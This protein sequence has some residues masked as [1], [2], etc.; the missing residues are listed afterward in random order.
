MKIL[1]SEEEWKVY[2]EKLHRS[3]TD[4]RTL[5]NGKPERF[6]CIVHTHIEYDNN[7][8]DYFMHDFVYSAGKCDCGIEKW[9]FD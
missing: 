3:K 2:S 5:D 7:G 9:K 1:N 4:W 8:P 6:P